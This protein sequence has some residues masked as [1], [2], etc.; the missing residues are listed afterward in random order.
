VTIFRENFGSLIK[1]VIAKI[2]EIL[3]NFQNPEIGEKKNHRRHQGKES[4]CD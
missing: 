4:L 2:W 1:S 3:S